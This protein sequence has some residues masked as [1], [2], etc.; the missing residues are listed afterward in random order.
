MVE[1]RVAWAALTFLLGCAQEE[2]S[3]T[4]LVLVADTD[5]ARI[6]A[7]EF[8]IAADDAEPQ[9]AR[10]R[11]ESGSGPVY[12]TLVRDRG[13]LGPLSVRAR[14][15]D[16][17]E[18]VLERSHE[19]SF[20]AGETRVVTLHLAKSCL[21]RSCGGAQ[22]CSESGCVERALE[23]G[24]LASWSGSAP[25]LSSLADAGSGSAC[26]DAGEVDLRSNDAHCGRCFNACR[27]QQTCSAGEC[28]RK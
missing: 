9:S 13:P 18:L 8:N 22:T 19:L 3:L 27:A 28:V 6:D 2:E 14:G 4:Q 25:S 20:V 5:I 21:N 7:I 1:S 23:A 16:G 15:L 10:A 24:E 11:Y 17:T 26:G 12:V